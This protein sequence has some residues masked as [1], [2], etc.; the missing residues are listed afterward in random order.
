VALDPEG[1]WVP[2]VL[3]AASERLTEMR[4]SGMPD[5]G[6]LVLATDQEQ[7]RAYAAVLKKVT[8]QTPV[9]VLSDDPAASKKI[10]A[11]NDGDQHFIVA[12]RMVSEGSTSGVSAC[13]CG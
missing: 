7:A 11:F 3:E 9:L 6:C 5:A 10:K 12:V 2:H 13:W 4:G 1:D 8:G